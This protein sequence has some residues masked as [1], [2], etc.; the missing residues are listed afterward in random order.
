MCVTSIVV[1]LS[2]INEVNVFSSLYVEDL[3]LETV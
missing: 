2:G 3:Y 1:V